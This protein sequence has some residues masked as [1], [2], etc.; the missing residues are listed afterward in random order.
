MFPSNTR[1]CPASGCMRPAMSR[2]STVLP[3]PLPPMTTSVSPFWSSSDTPLST[4]ADSNPFSTPMTSMIP[5]TRSPEHDQQELG[6]EEVRHDHAHGDVDHGGRR[7]A[8]EPL[9]AALGGQPVIAA[10]QRHHDPEERALDDPGEEIAGDHPIGRRIP[11][12]PRV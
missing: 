6:E 1:I 2:S 9:G 10:D 4:G 12:R 7:R 8:P 5:L 3:E 11:V